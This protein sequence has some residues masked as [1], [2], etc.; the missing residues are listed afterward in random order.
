MMPMGVLL[1]LSGEGKRIMGQGIC[2]GSTRRRG[3][4]GLQLGC[5]VKN[6]EI[7]ENTDFCQ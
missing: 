1:L 3:G 7:L 5:T 4:R 2:K 6:K